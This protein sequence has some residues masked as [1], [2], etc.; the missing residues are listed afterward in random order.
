MSLNP[1]NAD[2]V[3]CLAIKCGAGAAST[4]ARRSPPQMMLKI[5][6]VYISNMNKGN[7]E[8]FQRVAETS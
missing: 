7:V 8:L 1:C 6:E 2:F 5:I 4:K 3:R